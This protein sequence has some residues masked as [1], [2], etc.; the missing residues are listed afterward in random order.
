MSLPAVGTRHE[1]HVLVAHPTMPA[2]RCGRV[3]EIFD[4]LW[5]LLEAS[6]MTLHGMA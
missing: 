4:L 1:V 2:A 3:R 5:H 6:M